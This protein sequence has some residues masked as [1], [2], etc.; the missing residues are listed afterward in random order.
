[1]PLSYFHNNV[2]G[3][4]NLLRC[5]ELIDAQR[6][7]FSSSATVYGEPQQLPLTEETPTNITNPYGRT[8]L[9]VEEIIRDICASNDKFSG[10][11]LRYFNPVGA[12]PSGKIGEVPS[13]VPNNLMPYVA[14]VCSGK[15][16]FLRVYGNDYDTRDGT[17]LR[18]YI[19]VEDL[20]AGHIAAVHYLL[21]QEEKPNCEV[22][23]LGTG[24]GLTVLEVVKAM[25]EAS[26][27]TIPLQFEGRRKGDVASC[28]ADA[29]L[30]EQKLKWKAT[31]GVTEMCRD[32]WNFQSQNPNG[33][34]DDAV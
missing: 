28:W 4:I 5:M 6:I 30:A 20:V 16:P 25:E 26:G 32:L 22:F 2:S 24:Q 33:Y 12:H 8:K 13:G 34:E 15:R 10:I 21:N 1:M 27:K 17:G 9:M 23:N 19:H 7:I 11:L 18:D 31:R 3:T 29:S 14:Q